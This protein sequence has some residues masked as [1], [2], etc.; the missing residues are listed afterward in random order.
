MVQADILPSVTP[1]DEVDTCPSLDAVQL[2]QILEQMLQDLHS[3]DKWVP[4]PCNH[5]CSASPTQ[6]APTP[7]ERTKPRLR[8]PPFRL[9]RNLGQ[10]LEQM[11]QEEILE[12]M[13]QEQMLERTFCLISNSGRDTFQ[14]I[15]SCTIGDNCIAKKL[16]AGSKGTKYRLSQTFIAH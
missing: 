7:R 8:P 4:T 12:Q 14:R 2:G 3:E 5:E 11:L 10:M 6:P 16:P 13:L 15:Q 1:V 9:M